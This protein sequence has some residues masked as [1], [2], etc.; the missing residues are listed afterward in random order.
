[1]QESEFRPLVKQF[2]NQFGF[3]VFDIPEN[4]KSKSPDFDVIGKSDRY[5]LELKIKGDDP[6]GIKNDENALLRGE[7]VSKTIPV[8]PRNTL[9][10][11]LRDGVKQNIDHDHDR[12]TYH[13]IWVHSAGQDPNLLNSRFHATLYGIET[14]FSIRKTNVITCYY[15]HNSAFFSWREFLDGVI[16]SYNDQIQLCINTLS[17]RV[18]NFRK[19]QLTVA[20]V[21]GLCDPDVL[22]ARYD[23]LYIADCEIDRNNEKE[24]LEYLQKKYGLD[25][26]QTIPMNQHTGSIALPTKNEKS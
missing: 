3:K 6:V 13:M 10:G 1:M 25:H 9:A 21:N 26:L 23:D 15:F 20:M 4:E 7:L 18:D 19:S 12:K 14:L 16:L 24:V 22:E 8:G 17:P 5:T 11:I 2:I